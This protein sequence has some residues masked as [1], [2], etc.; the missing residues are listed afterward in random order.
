MKT[1]R[2]ALSLLLLSALLTACIG[3]PSR[4]LAYNT[5]PDD[6]SGL[7]GTGIIGAITGFGSIFVNGVEVEI[8][9]RTRLSVDGEVV[10]EHPFARGEVVEIVATGKGLMHARELTVRHEVIG[11][12]E[13]S[14]LGTRTFRVLG[15]IVLAPPSSAALP[16][17]GERVAISGFRDPQGR[18]HATRVAPAGQTPGLVTGAL[19]Y[20]AQGVARIGELQILLPGDNRVTDGAMVRVTGKADGHVLTAQ[21]VRVLP[22]TPFGKAVRRLL[23]QGFLYKSGSGGYR[24]DRFALNLAPEGAHALPV[25]PDAPLRLDMRPGERGWSLQRVIRAEGLPMGRPERTPLNTPRWRHPGS[26][27]MP[28]RGMGGMG[29]WHGR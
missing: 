20:D 19:R 11:T 4:Q 17:P 5:G 3:N 6:E 15:Q 28:G 12:V 27:V 9:R 24:I 25:H 2:H 26:P 8:D 22:A 1:F 14:D 29:G 18:I 23:V 13:R 16:L 10:D 21:R 7:G